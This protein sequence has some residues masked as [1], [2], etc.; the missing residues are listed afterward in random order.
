MNLK[1]N[2]PSERGQIQMTYCITLDEMSRKGKV[3]DTEAHHY[4]L[5][6]EVGAGI[7]CN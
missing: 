3:T 5:W 2:T 6:W 1:N 7:D 4:G